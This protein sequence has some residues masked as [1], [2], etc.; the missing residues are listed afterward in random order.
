M[1]GF[2][3]HRLESLVFAPLTATNV[4][5]RNATSFDPPATD[6]DSFAAAS[7]VGAGLRRSGSDFGVAAAGSA[8][9]GSATSAFAA[10]GLSQASASP[11][12]ASANEQRTQVS[13]NLVIASDSIRLS[14]RPNEAVLPCY[15]PTGWDPSEFAGCL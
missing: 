7:P 4:P 8:V 10:G 9:S 13:E 15:P 11:A 1:V 5:S 12:T 3:V 14:A 2:L 6:F